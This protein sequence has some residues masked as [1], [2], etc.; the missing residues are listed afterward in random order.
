MKVHCDLPGNGIAN[1]RH[2]F[3]AHFCRQLKVK[4]YAHDMHTQKEKSQ[5][6]QI[7]QFKRCQ[8]LVNLEFSYVFHFT[9]Q[10][11]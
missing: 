11:F 8:K 6:E 1:F 9:L 3:A 7:I 2:N 5:I 4:E 10:K